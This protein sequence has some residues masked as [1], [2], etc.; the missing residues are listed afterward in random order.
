MLFPALSGLLGPLLAVLLV[1]THPDTSSI[2]SIKKH[3]KTHHHAFLSSS[4]SS[5]SIIWIDLENVRGRSGF[6]WSHQDVLDATVQWTRHWSLDGRVVVVADHGSVRAAYSYQDILAVVFSGNRAK[7]DDVL[8]HHVGAGHM[9]VTADTELQSRCQ[10][11]AS[12]RNK[13]QQQPDNSDR[14]LKRGLYF[15]DP[16][17]FLDDLEATLLQQQEDAPTS[18]DTPERLSFLEDDPEDLSLQRLDDEIQLRAMILDTQVQLDSRRRQQKKRN[19][20]NKKKKK[21]QSKLDALQ[22]KLVVAI[23]NNNGHSVLDQITNNN[24]SNDN[25]EEQQLIL[26][27]WKDIQR[28]RKEQ[29][30]DRVVL[31]EQL[32]RQLEAAEQQEDTILDSW[33]ESPAHEFIRHFNSLE[34][35][36]TTTQPSI[37][38]S[39]NAVLNNQPI[40]V[41]TNNNNGQHPQPTTQEILMDPTLNPLP[42]LK[43]LRIVAISDTHG[44][45]GQLL[46]DHEED[47]LSSQQ[48][49]DDDSA[50]L[51]GASSSDILPPGDILFHLGDFALEASGSAER[52]AFQRF[53][54]WLAKQPHPIKIV[55]RG[56][57][58]PPLQQFDQ[59]GA[60]Y[61]TTPTSIP[62]TPNLMLGVIPHGPSSTKRNKKRHPLPQSCDILA[63][64]VPPFKTLDRTFTGSAA[65][66]NYL[67][68]IVKS[69]KHG[70]PRLWL[71]G[72]IHEGRGV[73]QRQFGG[74]GMTTTVVNAANANPGR[75]THLQHE[76]VVIQVENEDRLLQR[77]EAVQIVSMEQQQ[78]DGRCKDASSMMTQLYEATQGESDHDMDTTSLMLAIDLGL[79]SG[80]A[81]FNSQGQLLRYEQFQFDIEDI[82]MRTRQLVLDWERDAN[83]E[84]FMENVANNG[85]DNNNDQHSGSSKRK[86]QLT[87]IAIEGVNGDMLRA[88]EEAA[89]SLSVLRVPPEEWRSELLHKKER[90]NGGQDAKAAAR[91]I[92]RQI[93]NDYGIMGVHEGK[94]KTDVAEA[95]CLGLY[96]SR[97]LGWI[98]RDPA[99]RRYS[100]GNIVVPPK[101]KP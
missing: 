7:A 92:A 26:Q 38:S 2:P 91:L 12:Q 15:L 46:T 39:S 21:L 67:T 27:R 82:A 28:T 61:I 97:R 18:N 62:L 59:S 80:A 25:T 22:T 53:D 98:Q 96:V 89:P 19:L 69:M 13:K 76:A 34:P 58:D 45:E 3:H 9:V 36:T 73:A 72:H 30:G 66:S 33:Q 99:V 79:K 29:T 6:R 11:G 40:D 52:K 83:D 51:N 4:S 49:K 75:A 94:F 41:T 5:S 23:K 10:R 60:W 90:C 84:T 44:F 93:V 37:V 43:T 74:R 85:N 8:A 100:N 54:Q 63:T 87:H 81:L 17:T 16:T 55:V 64:H 32:R 86:S 77:S 24:N 48:A 1:A 31:A 57:H 68:R 71:C 14:K 50:K 101:K 47:S 42:G 65:G 88:W 56:N 78:H 95:V 70:P 20:T 35:T